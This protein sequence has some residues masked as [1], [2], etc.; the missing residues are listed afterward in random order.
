M[1]KYFLEYGCQIFLV[2]P[3]VKMEIS[4]IGILDQNCLKYFEKKK[5]DYI[6]LLEELVKRLRDTTQQDLFSI[7]KDPVDS[8][9]KDA[10]SNKQ[11]LV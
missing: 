8:K 2:S 3:Q 11:F 1:S 10:K 9:K 6:K 5:F 4:N 7:S